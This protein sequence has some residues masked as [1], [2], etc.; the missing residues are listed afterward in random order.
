MGGGAGVN[1]CSPANPANQFCL[2]SH[3]MLSLTRPPTEGERL[4]HIVF[5]SSGR[6]AVAGFAS[7]G[8][9]Y[10]SLP[11]LLSVRGQ[12]VPLPHDC[13]HFL[14]VLSH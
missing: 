14:H 7:Q 1:Y 3:C 8:Q 5:V 4:C 9:T 11:P 10:T 6:Q 12:T 13:F 2:I